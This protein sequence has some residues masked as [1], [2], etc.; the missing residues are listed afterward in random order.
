MKKTVYE[1]RISDWSSD[2]C[3]SDLGRRAGRCDRAQDQA[4]AGRKRAHGLSFGPREA[5]LFDLEEDGRTPR[6]LRAGD[7]HHGLSRDLRERGRLL[8]RA[9]GAAHHLAVPAW[10]VQGLYLH[11]QGQR[12]SLAPHLPDVREFDAAGGSDPP[13]RQNWK[14]VASETNW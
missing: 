2:V 13:P 4:G 7:R 8:P 5:S 10:Q 14:S 1:M 6:Q 11:P 12:L 3:S 9:G